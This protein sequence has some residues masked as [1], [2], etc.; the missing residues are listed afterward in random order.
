MFNFA[1]ERLYYQE[2]NLNTTKGLMYFNKRHDSHS[3]SYGPQNEACKVK[4]VG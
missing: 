4:W 1:G 2:T 3:R